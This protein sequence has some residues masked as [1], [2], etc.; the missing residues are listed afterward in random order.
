MYPWQ[1][2]FVRLTF[3]SSRGCNSCTSRNGTGLSG[4]M[5]CSAR[6]I[7]S[8][9]IHRPSEHNVELSFF[10]SLLVSG[11][12]NRDK[13]IFTTASALYLRIRSIPRQVFV[14]MLASCLLCSRARFR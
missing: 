12:Q 8:H 2:D 11:Q 7:R 9:I 4:D 13:Q 6:K 14:L 5:A 10:Y 3:V 1:T